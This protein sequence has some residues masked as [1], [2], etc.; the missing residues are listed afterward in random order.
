MYPNRRGKRM[1]PSDR[2]TPQ[3]A[4]NTAAQVWHAEQATPRLA[5][6]IDHVQASDGRRIGNP[7][8]T[9]KVA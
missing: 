3:S 6:Q 1:D 2:R 7:I 9:A 8:P 4:R 5:H